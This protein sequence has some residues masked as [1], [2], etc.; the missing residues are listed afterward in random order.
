MRQFVYMFDIT[1]AKYHHF[2]EYNLQQL[3]S[4]NKQ[5]LQVLCCMTNYSN[6]KNIIFIVE[7]ALLLFLIFLGCTRN[8]ALLASFPKKSDSIT[9]VVDPGHGGYDPGKVGVNNTLEKDIN[10]SISLELT[11]LLKNEGYNVILTRTFDT[12]LYEEGSHNKKT[13][14]LNNRIEI[15]KKNKAD[16]AICIHQNSF[17]DAS[18]KGAQV[19]YYASNDNVNP[20][21]AL[22]ESIQNALIDGL[23][24]NNT[25]MAKSNTS[26]YMLKHT[27]CPTVIVE[28]GF[29][30]N[31]AEAMLLNSEKYQ[32][33]I[34]QAICIGINN[35]CKTMANQQ[36]PERSR[37]HQGTLSGIPAYLIPHSGIF[38]P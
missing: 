10:L 21:K 3:I 24:K 16:F 2:L 32:M 28:S 26:Y 20:S 17:P 37:Q 38:K 35:Y 22:A 7:A 33:Q 13:D 5:H 15:I 31:P 30:S 1:Y 19:F 14:D 9:I 6:K 25:R 18:V 8:P 29:L 34:A 12:S 36:T 27:A 4:Y 23:D 11:K